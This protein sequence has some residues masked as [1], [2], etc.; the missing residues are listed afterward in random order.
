MQAISQF[1]S[2]KDF[3][4]YLEI[5]KKLDTEENGTSWEKFF[6]HPIFQLEKPTG[7][8]GYKKPDLQKVGLII[9][10]SPYG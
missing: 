6:K 5:A 1:L 3:S 7:F 8:S 2:E 10:F 9:A 4:K